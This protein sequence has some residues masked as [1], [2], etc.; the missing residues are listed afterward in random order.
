MT[1]KIFGREPAAIAGLIEGA[2]ALLLAFGWLS[3]IGLR[4]QED[5]AVV[6]A[7]VS[8]AMGV[9]VAWVTDE[10]LLG[11]VLGLV[12][13]L[14]ALGAV[15]GLTLSAEETGALIAFLTVALG[16]W[17]RDKVEPLEQPTF[18]FIRPSDTRTVGHD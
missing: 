5:L 14:I 9:Y 4:G 17:Q 11:Y 18:S 7:V 16:F 10:T 15:Y 12:K 6:M 1:A 8:G 2:L 13:A 3:F